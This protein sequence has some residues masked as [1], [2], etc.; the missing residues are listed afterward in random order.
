MEK[1]GHVPSS[2]LAIGLDFAMAT[3]V[4]CIKGDVSP[5][6][7][8]DEGKRSSSLLW[9]SVVKQNIAYTHAQLA[10]SVRAHV[11][12][13]TVHMLVSIRTMTW[14]Y[15]DLNFELRLLV[16]TCRPIRRL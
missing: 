9:Y 4:T 5:S 15:K 14:V 6:I 12:Y 13:N 10:S 7:D 2:S 16:R 8:E 1:S 3:A 11:P